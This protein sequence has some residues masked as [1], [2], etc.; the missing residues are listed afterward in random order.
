MI[1]EDLSKISDVLKITYNANL[2]TIKLINQELY[3]SLIL[4][5]HAIDNNLYSPNFELTF[6]NDYF[7]IYNKT[8]NQDF[9]AINSK[10]SATNDIKKLDFTAQNTF[11]TLYK[12]YYNFTNLPDNLQEVI[13]EEYDKS[14][15][16]DLEAFNKLIQYDIKITDKQF[17]HFDKFI[18]LGTFLFSHIQ[19][20]HKKFKPKIYLII[21]PNIELFRLSLFTFDLREIAK[22]SI[23][24]LSVGD[25]EDKLQQHILEFLSTSPQLN[26][27]IK[28]FLSS[29]NYRYL[30]KEIASGL[31]SAIDPFGFHHRAM[32]NLVNKSTKSISKKYNILEPKNKNINIF[33]DKPI[34]VLSPGPSLSKMIPWILNAQNKFIIVAFAASLTR[35]LSENIKPDIIINV[36]SNERMYDHF[37]ILT[38]Y[39]SIANNTIYLGV[40]STTEKILKLFRKKN[41]FLFE[42]I[43]SFKND[44]LV[45]LDGL[46]VGEVTMRLLLEFNAKTIYLLGTD[47][48]LNEDGK[49]HDSSHTQTGSI[50]LDTEQSDFSFFNNGEISKYKQT[51]TMKGNFKEQVTSTLMFY[52]IVNIY[53]II[54]QTYKKEFQTVYNMSDG[55]MIDG[56]VPKKT[57]EIDLESFHEIDKIV[58]HNDFISNL[59]LMSDINLTKREQKS[60]KKIVKN[61]NKNI[62]QPKKKAINNFQEYQEARFE[63]SK[64]LIS[65]DK[66]LSFILQRYLLIIE[67][68]L[69]YCSNNINQTSLDYT[70]IYHNVETTVFDISKKYIKYCHRLI[71]E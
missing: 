55:A 7:N 17:D 26:Y 50:S 68:A 14:F 9:F 70:K 27:T 11:N 6:T 19:E 71:N 37:K 2:E 34:L 22:D 31:S 61:I 40:T 8:T 15:Y 3:N 12:E 46:T 42:P 60:L 21:E 44:S 48:A 18:V 51:I 62:S 43:F 1:Y 45:E 39:E 47:L 56:A 13:C 20:I 23:I 5:E 16:Y 52:N 28:F 64:K 49:T 33:D 10:V 53:N 29:D 58:L 35:L 36:D 32:L 63:L 25:Q 54:L 4:L 41:I 59:T 65:Q 38:K 67:L 66:F 57:E 30:L 24:A 69:E